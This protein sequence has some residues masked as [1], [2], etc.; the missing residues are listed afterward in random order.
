MNYNLLDIDLEKGGARSFVGHS[1]S[2]SSLE[3]SVA[4]LRRQVTVILPLPLSALPPGLKYLI[5]K[6]KSLKNAD[7]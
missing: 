5:P 1:Q 6:P 3:P 7:R 4:S 2:T